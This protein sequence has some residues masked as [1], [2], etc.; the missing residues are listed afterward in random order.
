MRP[1]HTLQAGQESKSGEQVQ[2]GVVFH[3]GLDVNQSA[4]QLYLGK[5][6]VQ[7]WEVKQVDEQSP[8][9]N[10]KY[11]PPGSHQVKESHSSSK[12]AAPSTIFLEMRSIRGCDFSICMHQ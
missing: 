3:L 1:R 2:S 4:Y 10:P 12:I 9:C 5:S 7:H 6:Q 11:I 8:R